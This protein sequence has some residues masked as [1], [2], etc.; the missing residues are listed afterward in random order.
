MI[1]NDCAHAALETE[2]FFLILGLKIHKIVGVE[3]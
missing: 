1:D 2:K 3:L